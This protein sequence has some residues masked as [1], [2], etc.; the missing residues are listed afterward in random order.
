MARASWID[1]DNHPDLDAHVSQL[2]HFTTAIADGV[3]DAGELAIQADNLKAAMRAVE[4]T[5]SDE[6]HAAVTKLL[7]ETCAYAVMQVLHDMVQAKAQARAQ[8]QAQAAAQPAA[9]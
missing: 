8:A 1:D 4:G 9:Q 6:Q 2:E 7:A 5:L 3:V